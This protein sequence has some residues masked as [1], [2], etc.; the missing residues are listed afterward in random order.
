MRVGQIGDDCETFADL[1]PR[2]AR[3]DAAVGHRG[4]LHAVND[5]DSTKH[6]DLFRRPIMLDRGHVEHGLDGPDER[7]AGDPAS[8]AMRVQ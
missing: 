3:R 6:R 2:L 8:V 4:A 7:A 1:W 5:H